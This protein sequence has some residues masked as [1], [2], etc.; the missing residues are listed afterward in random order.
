MLVTAQKLSEQGI[1]EA[2]FM[3]SQ[4]LQVKAID[5]LRKYVAYR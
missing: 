3:H 4:R 2:D 1:E 5:A